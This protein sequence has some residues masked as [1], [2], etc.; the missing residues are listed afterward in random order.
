M[1]QVHRGDGRLKTGAGF[2]HPNGNREDLPSQRADEVLAAGVAVQ[3]IPRDFSL[4]LVDFSVRSLDGG[5]GDPS[6]S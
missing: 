2:G 3:S 6:E 5:A 1:M 4:T